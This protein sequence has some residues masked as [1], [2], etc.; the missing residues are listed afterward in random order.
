MSAP[1]TVLYDDSPFILTSKTAAHHNRLNWRAQVLLQ[2][3]SQAL[4]GCRVLD[5]AS[6]DGRFS[7]ACLRLGATSVLG[8]E[9]RPHLVQHA[10][11]NLRAL[12]VA[13]QRW[14]FMC[15][16][17]FELL[18][19]LQPGQFDTVLCLGFI[20]HTA[21]QIELLAQLQRLKPRFL[22]LDARVHDGDDGSET[23]ALHFTT[24]DPSKES[25]TC[26]ADGVVAV[27]NRAFLE[28]FCAQLGMDADFVDWS[29]QGIE[30]WTKL[31]DYRSGRRLSCLARRSRP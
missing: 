16:D 18:L 24:E 3:N 30:D 29:D 6:H 2:Q 26:A 20:Y 10:E 13:E 7:Y 11:A 12:G 27:P 1:F 9:A 21:R 17:L 8:L 22:V 31:K 4:S 23:A 25:C 14:Q 19:T 5:L 28:L 15:G